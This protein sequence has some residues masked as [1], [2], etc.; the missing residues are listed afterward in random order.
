MAVRGSSRLGS[1]EVEGLPSASYPEPFCLCHGSSDAAASVCRSSAVWNW[2]TH[3][4]T[5]NRIDPSSV[6]IRTGG[7]SIPQTTQPAILPSAPGLALS[8]L[9]KHGAS[10]GQDL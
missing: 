8:S 3:R 6:P 4:Q 7:R 10:H 1:T 2:T 5:S 9:L